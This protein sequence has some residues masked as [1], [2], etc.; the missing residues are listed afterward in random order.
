MMAADLLGAIGDRAA[1]QPLIAALK[2]VDPAVVLAS[3]RAL[4]SLGD[5]R[6][7][8]PLAALAPP[9]TS[10]DTDAEWR[11][12]HTVAKALADL[13]QA[14]VPDLIRLIHRLDRD[15]RQWPIRWLAGTNDPRAIDE[16]IRLLRGGGFE[17]VYAARALADARGPAVRAALV[18]ALNDGDFSVRND[19]ARSL[20]TVAGPDAVEPLIGLAGDEDTMV[21]ETAASCLGSLGDPRAVGPLVRLCGDQSWGVRYSAV[22]SLGRLGS[23]DTLI[24]L[25]ERLADSEARVRE[26]AAEAINAITA[27]S[28][29]AGP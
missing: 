26:A 12:R 29:A 20:V 14:G 22:R 2:D 5:G 11:L 25:R 19:A 18:E 3:A 23:S 21:R 15:E 24:A 17:A 10:S 6:A 4:G 16:V 7:V 28:P 9:P 1:V 13:G 8:G 27:P